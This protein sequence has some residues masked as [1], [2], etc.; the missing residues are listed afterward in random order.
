MEKNEVYISMLNA[1]YHILNNF[2]QSM[3][4]F[5]NVAENSDDIGEDIL[6]LYD[7]A[8][9]NTITQINKF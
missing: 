2:L 7:K 9:Q 5:R 1:T 8:I 4:L 6:K 3:M